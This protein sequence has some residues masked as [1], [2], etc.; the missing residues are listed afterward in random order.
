MLSVLL[1]VLFFPADALAWGPVAHIDFS[2]QIL[3]GVAALTPALQRLIRRRRDEFIYGSLAADA[4]IG[5][6]LAGRQTHCH[7]WQ[8]ALSLLADARRAGEPF[9]AFLLGYLSHLGADVVAHNHFV[10]DRMVAHYR[11]LGLGHLYWEARFD[12][13]LL[14]ISPE[15]GRTW[16]RLSEARFPAFD[17]FL[18]ERLKPTLFSHG[19]SNHIYHRSLGLQRNRPWQG[20]LLRIDARSK[21]PIDAAEVERWRI[22]SVAWAAMALNDPGCE[23]L[24][25]EDPTGQTA[26][27][28]SGEMR[29]LLRRRQRRLGGARGLVHAENVGRGRPVFAA[30]LP[31]IPL[32][33]GTS[34]PK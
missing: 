18:A 25:R 14:S 13:R 21:Y 12:N 20:T 24:T 2:V 10:P 5:K 8:V 17:R 26:L 30:D 32:A 11:A 23:A 9:E 4:V 22:V 31:A 33:E 19:V 28:Q 6:N 7:S 15:V 34:A 16:K 1:G 27:A 3:A 29:R